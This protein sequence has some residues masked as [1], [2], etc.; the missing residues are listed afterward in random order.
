MGRRPEWTF[1][2]R[3]C[4]NSQSAH[5]KILNITNNLGK[6]NENRKIAPHTYQNG[7]C[8]KDNI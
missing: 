8:Q 2:Q 3:K 5:E 1:S 7:Y 4:T 6:V